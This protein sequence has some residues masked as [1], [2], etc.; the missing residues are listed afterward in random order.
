[1]CRVRNQIRGDCRRSQS[2][3]RQSPPL[4]Q[5]PCMRSRCCERGLRQRSP[6]ALQGGLVNLDEAVL[7]FIKNTP[8]CQLRT[9]RAHIGKTVLTHNETAEILERLERRGLIAY[10][11]GWSFNHSRRKRR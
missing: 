9:I 4:V 8:R 5:V 10:D 2:E 11:S 3:R 1:M 7:S 6:P